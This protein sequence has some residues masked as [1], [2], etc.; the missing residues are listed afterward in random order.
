[1]ESQGFSRYFKGFFHGGFSRGLGVFQSISIGLQGIS[2]NL[3]GIQRFLSRVSMDFS[4]D[5]K[6]FGWS[7]GGAVLGFSWTHLKCFK[8][9]LTVVERFQGI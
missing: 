7:E 5:F 2:S 6:D 9:I 8:G 4:R 1:M 3:K